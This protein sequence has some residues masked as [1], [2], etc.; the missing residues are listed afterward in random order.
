LLRILQSLTYWLSQ[1]L[2][3]ETFAWP[4]WGHT[5]YIWSDSPHSPQNSAPSRFS[6]PQLGHFMSNAPNAGLVP[7]VYGS[8]QRMSSV[9]GKGLND[10][11]RC[12]CNCYQQ[13]LCDPVLSTKLGETRIMKGIPD[14]WRRSGLRLRG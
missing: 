7:K 12:S 1:N 2:L 10:V 9:I 11:A 8:R 14:V 4:H 13:L 3:L 5:S 6:C